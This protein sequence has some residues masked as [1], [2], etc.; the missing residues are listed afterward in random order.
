MEKELSNLIK[1]FLK[2]SPYITTKP[3]HL[4]R[5]AICLIFPLEEEPV[6]EFVRI[7]NGGQTL[8]FTWRANLL[9]LLIAKG[10]L[11]LTGHWCGIYV[12]RRTLGEL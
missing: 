5:G 2:G 12:E 8:G 10:S 4:E 9:P 3:A 11:K 7:L 1:K 6:A